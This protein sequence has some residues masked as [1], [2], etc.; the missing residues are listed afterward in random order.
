MSFKNRRITTCIECGSEFLTLMGTA[1]YC[2]ELCKRKKR[3]VNPPPGE[4][5]DCLKCGTRFTA[6]VPN[7]RYCSRECAVANNLS[8]AVR[9]QYRIFERDSFRC[10]YCGRSS[11]EHG[12]VLHV[13]H[14]HPRSDG[15]DKSAGNLVTSCKTCNTSKRNRKLRSDI[16]S[17]ILLLVQLR[18]ESCGLPSHTTI[19]I[20]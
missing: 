3:L 9:D 4:Q 13:D 19:N 16:K 18:N 6:N 12:A 20:K 2:S 15:G 5:R 7:H 14:I 8:L 11:I 1:K 10:V 17:R